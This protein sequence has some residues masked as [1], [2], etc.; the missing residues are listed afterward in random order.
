[1]TRTETHIVAFILLLILVATLLS[2]CA[3]TTRY[4]VYDPNTGNKLSEFKTDGNYN[5][6]PS[7]TTTDRNS[8]NPLPIGGGSAVDQARDNS[9]YAVTEALDDTQ[10]TIKAG[11]LEIYGTIDHAT[12]IRERWI[13]RRGLAKSVVTGVLGAIGLGEWGRSAR[14]ETAVDMAR[15]TGATQVDV[16]SLRTATEQARIAADSNVAI[17]AIQAASP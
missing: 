16:E 6:E 11:E 1:M 4:T 2:G 10:P 8:I 14:A 15:T 3:G 12:S 9:A 17:E 5:L 13:G 7:G